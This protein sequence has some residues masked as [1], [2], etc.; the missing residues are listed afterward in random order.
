M[1]WPGTLAAAVAV[2][3]GCGDDDDACPAGEFGCPCAEDDGCSASGAVCLS[4]I[5][6]GA[7]DAGGRAMRDA[8]GP[9]E[10]DGGR[11]EPSPE[12]GPADASPDSAAA[13]DAEAGCGEVACNAGDRICVGD[14]LR[15][16]NAARDGYQRL[17]TCGAGLCDETAG[18]C[19]VCFAGARDCAGDSARE[20]R[21]DGQGYTTSACEAPVPHCAGAGVCVECRDD[22]DCGAGEE[23][24]GNACEVMPFCGDGSVTTGE[25]CDPAA[26]GHSAFT[27][28]SACR[29]VTLYTSCAGGGDDACAGTTV[30]SNLNTCGNTCETI[31]DCDAVPGF[32]DLDIQCPAPLGTYCIVRCGT[33]EDCPPGTQCNGASVCEGL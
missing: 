27:C 10:R 26:S 8:D 7:A 1:L 13:C 11:V 12:G 5:C 20:C 29:T 3:C 19:D 24:N 30:C 32:P 33:S 28:S 23:C 17:D 2:L 31:S 22:D 16:C 9:P 25:D 18:E 15:E 6:V 21:E 4:G 14:E